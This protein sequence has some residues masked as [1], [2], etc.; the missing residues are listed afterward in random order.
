VRITND[1][2][3]NR[4]ALI[5]S[6]VL[7]YGKRDI[8][9]NR[10]S[11]DTVILDNIYM[12]DLVWEQ[13]GT[14]PAKI[15]ED[16]DGTRMESDPSINNNQSSGL[17]TIVKPMKACTLTLDWDVSSEY[18][19]D[20]FYVVIDGETKLRKSG[21]KKET[22]TYV[23]ESAEDFQIQLFFKKDYSVTRGRD[24]FI[25]RNFKISLKED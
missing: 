5:N 2:I 4:V 24:N 3:N 18:Y 22:F 25:V 7:F 1:I 10:K 23:H 8:V 12:G 21:Y 13:Y 17:S 6:G 14:Q 20:Y 19:Y 11:E 15:Y 9:L 16:S